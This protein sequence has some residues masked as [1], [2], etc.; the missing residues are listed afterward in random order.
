MQNVIERI[1]GLAE[2]S[3]LM[4]ARESTRIVSTEFLHEFRGYL[5]DKG[6]AYD[7]SLGGGIFVEP[8]SADSSATRFVEMKK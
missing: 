3:H 7:L 2:W 8:H 6:A 1:D 4:T 5:A